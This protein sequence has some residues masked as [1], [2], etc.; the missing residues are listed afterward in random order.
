MS[1]APNSDNIRKLCK[2]LTGQENICNALDTRKLKDIV[3]LIGSGISLQGIAKQVDLDV[4]SVRAIIALVK[5]S[6]F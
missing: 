2:I 4:Y 1:S 6:R 5:E 3:R